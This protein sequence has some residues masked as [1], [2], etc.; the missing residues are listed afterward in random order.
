MLWGSGLNLEPRNLSQR[1]TLTQLGGSRVVV[2]GV[3]LRAPFKGIYRDVI[4]VSGLGPT[5]RFMRSYKWIYQY[6]GFRVS[7]VSILL[8]S[9]NP[10]L[11]RGLITRTYNPIMITHEPASKPRIPSSRPEPRIP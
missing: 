1:P 2:R 5:W 3:P 10:I 8:T 11:N 9:C 7:R 4:R 6:L